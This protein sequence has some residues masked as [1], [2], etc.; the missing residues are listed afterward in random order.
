MGRKK[1]IVTADNGIMVEVED[2]YS[3]T[4]ELAAEIEPEWT[5]AELHPVVVEPPKS[6]AKPAPVSGARKVV[7][8]GMGELRGAHSEHGLHYADDEV[9]TEHADALIKA[10]FAREANE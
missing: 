2:E 9:M 6:T 1:K 3:E 7:W 8:T 4:A 10:G 5:A